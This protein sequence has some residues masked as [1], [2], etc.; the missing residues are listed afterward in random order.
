MEQPLFPPEAN[1]PDN[2]DLVLFIGPEQVID[3]DPDIIA[4]RAVAG[5][6]CSIGRTGSSLISTATRF[7]RRVPNWRRSWGL[8]RRT[9]QITSKTFTAEDAEK[10]PENTDAKKA[11]DVSSAVSASSAVIQ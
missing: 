2:H 7:H 11:H 1:Q 8:T 6:P 3:L 10:L 4:V 5:A 9:V